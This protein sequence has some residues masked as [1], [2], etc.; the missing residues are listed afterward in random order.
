M[1]LLWFGSYQISTCLLGKGG[2]GG[3]VHIAREAAS[4]RGPN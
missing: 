2:G 1:K 4:A 3:Q